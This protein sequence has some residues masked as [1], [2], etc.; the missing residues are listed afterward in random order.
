MRHRD[1]T[2]KWT[3]QSHGVPSCLKYEHEVLQCKYSRCMGNSLFF[4]SACH[5]RDFNQFAKNF[6][7]F[8]LTGFSFTK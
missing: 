8:L 7:V 3:A 6:I 4:Q 2:L 1:A 5:S